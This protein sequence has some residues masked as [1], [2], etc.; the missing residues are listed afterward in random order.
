MWTG[1]YS[2]LTSY[3]V[4]MFTKLEQWF[5]WMMEWYMVLVTQSKPPKMDILFNICKYKTVRTIMKKV[6]DTP[7]H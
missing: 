6:P 2:E 4:H 7:M 1:F 5:D 3:I